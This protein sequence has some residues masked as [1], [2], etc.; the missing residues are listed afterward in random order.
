M[1]L[2]RWFLPS[3]MGIS[4]PVLFLG[5]VNLFGQLAAAPPVDIVLVLD[6]SRSMV[7]NDPQRLM[8]PALRAFVSELPESTNIGIVVFDRDARTVLDLTSRSDPEFNKRFADAL[9][10]VDYA[11]QWTDIAGGVERGVYGIRSAGRRDEGVGRA[12]I[13][14]T[15]GMIDLG[16]KELNK[17]RTA[18]LHRS[19]T[20]EAVRERV[21]IYGIAFT[22]SA[23]FQ[24]IQTLSTDT[25][26]RPFLIDKPDRISPVLADIAAA[27]RRPRGGADNKGESSRESLPSDNGRGAAWAYFVGAS[28]T[29]I[30]AVGSYFAYARLSTPSESAT[31]TEVGRT[32]QSYPIVKRVFR[33]GRKPRVGF[34]RIDLVIP[35]KERKMVSRF[36]AEIRYRRGQFFIRDKYSTHGTSLSEG[37]TT[38][39]RK[40]KPGELVPLSDGAHIAFHSYEYVFG[41]SAPDL[42]RG[43]SDVTKR[44]AGTTPEGIAQ[45]QK[46]NGHF[47]STFLTTW[48]KFVVCDQCRDEIDGLDDT[49]A[50][51][52]AQE[53]EDALRNKTTDRG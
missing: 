12:I 1:M 22:Y 13:L 30:L 38:R 28:L 19:V 32:S 42:R 29:G 24:L 3:L 53:M 21:A 5:A 40:V 7:T 44:E 16:P 49:A 51:R 14:F 20:A 26:G 17:E 31:L 47:D 43:E 8:V 11:G 48:K 27:L 10:K 18:W 9:R 34:R 15:D 37:Q 2:C 35:D 41:S 45:C 50:K 52:L 23:D 4:A 46:C 39:L 25:S 36:H 33:I 6:N